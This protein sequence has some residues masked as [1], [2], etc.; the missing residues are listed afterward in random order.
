MDKLTGLNPF[1]LAAFR[2]GYTG[3]LFTRDLFSGIIVALVAIPLSLAIA[4]ASG[5]QP[6]AGIITAIVGGLAIALFGGSRV[7]VGGPA[8]A[9]IVIVY[10]LAQQYGIVALQLAT[11]IAGILL[12]AAALFR[13]GSLVRYVPYPVITGFT[14]GIAVIIFT[15]QLRDALGLTVAKMPAEFLEVLHTLWL[16]LGTVNFWA[17]GTTAVALAILLLTPRSVARFVPPI[18]I[19]VVLGA[20]AAAVFHLPVA[21]IGTKFGG[22]SLPWALPQLPSMDEVLVALRPA[23]VIGALVAIE[24][25]LSAS[26]ADNKTG[27]RHKPSQELFGQGIANIISPLVGGIPATG[28]I[29]RTSLNIQSNGATPVAAA[30]HGIFVF[31]IVLLAAPYASFIPLSVLAAVLMVTALRMG[32]WHEIARLRTMPRSDAAVFLTTFALTVLVDLA[33]AVEIGLLVAG[34]LYI[35]RVSSETSISLVRQDT[36]DEHPLHSIIGRDLPAGIAVYQ[37]R[38]AFLF[39]ASS[40][41][42]DVVD[43][44]KGEVVVIRCRQLLSIDDS[45]VQA[46][47]TIHRRLRQHGGRLLLSGLSGQPLDAIEKTGFAAELGAESLP[48]HTEQAINTAAAHLRTTAHP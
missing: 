43:T 19:V 33:F 30:L 39:G 2:R 28:V 25:L 31:A 44:S 15:S 47:R 38:G 36:D 34:V 12:V 48:E 32:E 45:G 46:L 3:A 18:L 10:A 41:L 1:L 26:V 6:G 37:I 23:A 21:T 9:F 14:C 42:E 11:L 7:Q 29:A 35:R 8:G 17:V 16:H 5:V 27:D 22:L 20:I 13:L 24:S 4:I 40:R